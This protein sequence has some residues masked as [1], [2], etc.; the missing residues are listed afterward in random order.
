[1][2]WARVRF[3]V[4]QLQGKEFQVVGMG[5]N[6]VDRI[7]TVARYPNLGGKEKILNEQVL[8]GGQVATAMIACHVLGLRKVRYIGKVGDN[9]YGRISRQSLEES[10]VDCRYLVTESGTANQAAVILVDAASGERTI[11]WQR[12]DR[13]NFRPGELTEESVCCAPVLHL[14]GHDEDAALWC[15]RKAKEHGITTVLDI[16]KV[17]RRSRELLPMIDFCIMSETFPRVLTGEDNLEKALKATSRICSGFLA[18]TLGARG[19]CFLWEDQLLAVPGYQIQAVD[20]TGAGDVFHGAFIYA[21]IQGWPLSRALCFAN[22]AAAL[23]CTV[24]GARGGLRSADDVL[25]FMKTETQ[26]S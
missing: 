16:D 12:S 15:A 21:L 7:L 10:G 5:L 20:T 11:F 13:L 23:G 17:R 4:P 1:M 8:P 26:I 14:D 2:N 24:R 6:A 22:A 3:P 18:S 25:T 19:V 9:D